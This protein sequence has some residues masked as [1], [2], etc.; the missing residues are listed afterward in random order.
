MKNYFHYLVISLIHSFSKHVRA[1][2]YKWAGKGALQ[3]TATY[4]PTHV[5][6]QLLK[7]YSLHSSY[8][9]DPENMNKG[10]APVI[11]DSDSE[12]D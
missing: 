7:K 5:S 6:V 9:L 11:K 3:L 10:I 4:L 12:A 1:F 8:T 2:H